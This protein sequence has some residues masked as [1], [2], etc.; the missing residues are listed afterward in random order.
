MAPRNNVEKLPDEI[1]DAAYALLQK[2]RTIDEITA[3]LQ[4]L[5]A[6]VSRA[7]VGRWKQN[8]EKGMQA[9]KRAQALGASWAKNLADDPKGDVSRLLVQL[10]ETAVLDNILAAQTEGDD[11]EEAEPIGSLELHRLATA[12]QKF[13]AAGAINMERELR[14]KR[15]VLAKAAAEVDQVAKKRGL[16][17][18]AVAEIRQKILGVA[19]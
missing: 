6:D 16:T 15:D 18:E 19:A 9:L 13:A 14:I 5:G 3:H 7:G 17:P 2:G 10:G 1:R 4:A 12:T 8:A 11:G